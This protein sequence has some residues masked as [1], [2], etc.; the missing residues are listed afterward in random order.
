VSWYN[1]TMDMNGQNNPISPLRPVTYRRYNQSQILVSGKPS[2]V[3]AYM[4][5][6]HIENC[7]FL[8]NYGA[9]DLVMAQTNQVGASIG[10]RWRV[11]KNSFLNGGFDTDDHTAV[12]GWADDVE[13]SGNLVQNTVLPAVIGRTGGNTC[14]EIHGNRHKVVDNTFA[15]YSRGMWVSSN[16]TSSEA[17][18]CVI[19][20]NVFTTVFYGI[21]FFRTAL[22]LGKTSN[23]VISGNAFRFDS[24]TTPAPAPDIKVAIQVASAYEQGFV[25]ID[26]NTATSTDTVVGTVFFA[27]TTQSVSGQPQ[28][29]IVVTNNKTKGF[30]SLASVDSRANISGFGNITISNNTYIEPLLTPSFTLGIGVVVQSPQ[31][32]KTLTIT[33]NNFIDERAPSKITYGVYI[34]DSNIGYLNYLAGTVNSALISVYF[35]NGTNTINTKTGRWYFSAAPTAG[36]WS[37]GNIVWNTLP[38]SGGPPGWMCVAS[39]TPGTW[40]AMA[41]LA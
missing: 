39:G 17:V 25:L 4:D 34:S 28:T 12:F 38:S 41:N 23:L 5:D 3:V 36:P 6:V 35:E 22:T 32:V 13:F 7:R 31:Q 2:G 16:L 9:C 26:G 11:V 20:N 8:N 40:K 19:S 30:T 29:D 1:L 21:D 15:G 14:Y 10:R 27:A 37:R 24:S 18:D 33:G